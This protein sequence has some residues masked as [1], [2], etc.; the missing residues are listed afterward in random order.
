[1]FYTMRFLLGVAEAG[2]FP[3][4]I[5]YL[6]YWFPHA[7][8]GRIT[9]FFMTA[10]PLS[11]LIG[12]PISGWIMSAFHGD[13]GMQ[14]WQWLFVLEGI[15]SIIIGVVVLMWLDDRI[16][17]AKWL[18]ESERSVLQRNIAAEEKE[19]EDPPIWQAMAKPRVWAMASIY[20]S[21]VMG[22][23][24]VGFW[25]PTLI[26]NTGVT[27]PLVIGFLTAV[28]NLFAVVGMI[29]ISR[30]SDRNRER[31]WHLAIPALIGAV[32]LVVSAM[33]S[34]STWIAIIA[35]TVANIGICTVL[36]LFWS[37]PT[38][39]LGGTAAAAGIALINSVSNLAGFVSPFLVG[40]LK[41]QTGTTNSGIYLLA[42]CLCAG[43]LIALAQ[44]AKLVNR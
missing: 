29:L 44:P 5:L 9:T 39:V 10:V 13:H 15:P 26:R 14:G 43:A 25:M 6:T 22:L 17:H 40:W 19:K 8:R 7:R 35:L 20:F 16:S 36:P 33:W 30:N 3:G 11:G 24:G 37:L 32:G 34:G 1:M 31:R 4:I 18:T 12:G 28:P 27:E 23:Y 41:D 42:A 21:F 2:F 38:A